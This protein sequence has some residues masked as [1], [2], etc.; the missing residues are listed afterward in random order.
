[1]GPRITPLESTTL[2]NTGQ[3]IVFPIL[4]TICTEG[5]FIPT[6]DGGELYLRYPERIPREWLDFSKASFSSALASGWKI[7]DINDT[8]FIVPPDEV[9][10]ETISRSDYDAL[11]SAK[12]ARKRI[13]PE[14]SMPSISH[15]DDVSHQIE[16]LCLDSTTLNDGSGRELFFAEGFAYSYF[17]EGRPVPE[18]I[19][20][21]IG[22]GWS[23]VDIEGNLYIL[24]PEGI[25][26]ASGELDKISADG[27]R[28]LRQIGAIGLRGSPKAPWWVDKDTVTKAPPQNFGPGVKNATAGELDID[29]FQ[30]KQ[31]NRWGAEDG[32]RPVVDLS[33]YRWLSNYP[34]LAEWLMAHLAYVEPLD[35]DR[36]QNS[37]DA[38]EANSSTEAMEPIFKSVQGILGEISVRPQIVER[39]RG[40]LKTEP[41]AFLIVAPQICSVE[42]S[43]ASDAVIGVITTD[44]GKTALRLIS[45]FEITT[46]DRQ[47]SQT[48]RQ[49]EHTLVDR[50]PKGCHLRDSDGKG[51]TVDIAGAEK[52]IEASI[53]ALETDDDTANVL[54]NTKLRASTRFSQLGLLPPVKVLS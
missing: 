52:P 44:G 41:A 22:D 23:L 19:S 53:V 25:V 32:V 33:N 48:K 15:M 3:G 38:A 7:L 42:T 39:Y 43:E 54:E 50:F 8:R 20:R 34:E 13:L 9:L 18:S 10:T 17:V 6:A 35:M 16:N 40:M 30:I 37:I 46:S 11:I 14:T 2:A 21:A 31:W 24:P 5:T 45:V 1:M 26:A 4:S 47:G 36:L 29:A 28:K 49:M 12:V 27:L 51:I